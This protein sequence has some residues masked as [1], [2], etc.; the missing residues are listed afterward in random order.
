MNRRSWHETTPD[1]SL[2]EPMSKPNLHALG[3][4]PKQRLRSSE[5]WIKAEEDKKEEQRRKHAEVMRQQFPNPA[6][7]WMVEEAE[8]R[9]MA[10]QSGRERLQKLQSR[11][12]QI[13]QAAQHYPQY[14]SAVDPASYM[15]PHQYDLSEGNTSGLSPHAADLYRQ[16]GQSPQG[17][18]YKPPP[19]PPT[20]VMEHIEAPD[21]DRSRPSRPIPDTIKQTLIQR[22]T[23]PKSPGRASSYSPPEPTT[24]QYQQP[25]RYNQPASNPAG[26]SPP[27]SSQ[28]NKYGEP[29]PYRY[30]DSVPYTGGYSPTTQSSAQGYHPNSS[31]GYPPVQQQQ[32]S[33]Y[34]PQAVSPHYPGATHDAPIKPPRSTRDDPT[35]PRAEQVIVNGRQRCSHCEQALG[36][37]VCQEQ[38]SPMYCDY[39]VQYK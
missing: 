22:V 39:L 28:Y 19:P 10:E 36:E 4:T 12:Q 29:A 38:R 32:P 2:G 1:R 5:D 9:R 25:Q 20:H 21:A 31:S 23:S 13:A 30:P 37:Q 11:Q 17:H 27:T 24:S 6:D 16:T 18:S 35:A 3:A 33:G 14:R 7:H 15:K 8:R 26:Y 34:H